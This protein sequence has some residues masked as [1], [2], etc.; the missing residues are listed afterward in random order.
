MDF[1]FILLYINSI[2]CLHTFLINQI[3]PTND[4]IPSLNKRKKPRRTHVNNK[5]TIT[6]TPII[7][8]NSLI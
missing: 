4:Q 6:I 2:L 5:H 7:I 8:I 1:N 3:A